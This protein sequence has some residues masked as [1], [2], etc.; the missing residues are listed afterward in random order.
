[1][2]IVDGLSATKMI[3]EHEQ[4]M[5]SAGFSVTRIPIFAVSASLLEKDRETYVLSGF[6]GWL[7]KPIDFQRVNML[8]GGVRIKWMRNECVYEPGIWE[9]GGWFEKI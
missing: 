8:F 1:M 2:P 4:D 7:L 6:D 9:K 5:A 3:R